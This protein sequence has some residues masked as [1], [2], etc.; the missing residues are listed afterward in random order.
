MKLAEFNRI[1]NPNDEACYIIETSAGKFKVKWSEAMSILKSD[2]NVSLKLVVPKGLLV[3]QT[4]NTFIVDVI[5]KLNEPVMVA[6]KKDCYFIYAHSSFNKNTNNNVLACGV[7]ANT[8]C[9]TKHG[10]E[11]LLPWHGKDNKLKK[12]E[13]TS[14]VYGSEIG[15]LPL[16]LTPV[17]SHG[18]PKP[19]GFAIP[20]NENYDYVLSQIIFNFISSFT[21]EQQEHLIK[22][23]N[24]NLATQPKTDEE[25]QEFVSGLKDWFYWEFFT[26]RE[27]LQNKFGDY[28]IDYCEIKR[29]EISKKL[30]FYDKEQQIYRSD[31]DYIKGVM[32][33]LIPQLKRNQKEEA[34]AYIE[35]ILALDKKRFNSNPFI[36]VFKNGVLDVETLEFEEM[37]SDHLETI[38]INANYDPNAHSDTVDELFHNISR[39]DKDVQTLLYELIGYSMLKTSELAKAFLLVGR[40]RNGKSTYLDFVRE[41]LGKENCTAIGLKDLSNNFRTGNLA[42]KLASIAPDISAQQLAD[43]DFF[44]NAASGDRVNVEKKYEQSYDTTLFSTFILGCNKLPPSPD[45]SYG[46]YRRMTII[47]FEAN[48]EKVS[49][50]DGMNFKRNLMTQESI[51]YAAYKAVQAIHNV[52][53]TT[54]EF[55]LPEVVKRKLEEYKTKNS[56]VRLW[57]QKAPARFGNDPDFLRKYADNSSTLYNDYKDWCKNA[58]KNPLSQPNFEEEIYDEYGVEFK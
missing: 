29:D 15:D 43:S 46:Y 14:V 49:A 58:G 16:W 37:S 9:Y 38:R 45:R 48:L 18:N 27:F 30:Y 1:V 31:D 17:K 4:K 33:K 2:N 22:F 12:Y 44:K 42:D 25:L 7:D 57:R 56:T 26:G 28:V 51:D 50:V 8:I 34:L 3:I 20:I 13:D 36:V 54:K 40:G 24:A 10:T 53:V 19:I 6:K 32:T 52:L 21:R 41:I 39:N 55:T 23:I 11:I 47:P 35:D 5:K